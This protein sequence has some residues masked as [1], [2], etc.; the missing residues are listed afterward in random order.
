M[1]CTRPGLA[2][3]VGTISH[4]LSNLGRE[5]WNAEKW[6]MR[7]LRG[8][9]NMKLC[10]GNEK[11]ILVGYID[12]DMVGDIDSRRSTSGYLITYSGGVVA[13][14]SRLQKCVALSTIESDFIAATE[15]C[16]EMLWMK[17]FVQ[18][19]GFTQER[20]VLYCDSQSAIHLGKNSTF[21]ARSYHIDVRYD[22]IRDVL[23]AKLLELEKIYTDDNG[24]DMLTKALPRM[25]FEACCLT[26]GMEA[27]PT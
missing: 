24:A 21:Q 19:L 22:W 11:P 23:E 7:Y 20:Y 12:S 3:A 8:T 6:I 4:F 13:W 2:Y 26:S 17:K 9:S 15:A 5:H 18:E 10:F 16:K 1:V 27:F 25:K 14:Q